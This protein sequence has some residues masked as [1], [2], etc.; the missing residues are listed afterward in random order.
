MKR[1]TRMMMLMAALAVMAPSLAEARD[2]CRE[3]CRDKARLCKDRCKAGHPEGASPARHE[4]L[5]GCE[6]REDECRTHC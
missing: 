4:C 3:H 5:K 2:P 1:A 6:I